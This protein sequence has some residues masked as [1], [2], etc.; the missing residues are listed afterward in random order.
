MKILTLEQTNIIR[1]CQLSIIRHNSIPSPTSDT[2]KVDSSVHRTLSCCVIFCI[3]T[4]DFILAL[5]QI[6]TPCNM[7]TNL[8]CTTL[9]RTAS[10]N[11]PNFINGLAY[12]KSLLYMVDSVKSANFI[13][14]H[15]IMWTKCVWV[16]H[17]KETTRY[18]YWKRYIL[19]SLQKF[20][21]PLCIKE[22]WSRSAFSLL[23]LHV[24]CLEIRQ[25]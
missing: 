19:Y 5:S 6:N 1:T 13:K 11:L 22:L 21:Q 10:I 9:D 15:Y 23:V 7:L 18:N 4:A 20:E 24:V 17:M 3:F 12:C 8:V 2:K 16:I 25:I 14:I